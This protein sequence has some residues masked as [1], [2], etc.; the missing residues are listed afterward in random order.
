MY[1]ISNTFFLRRE[2]LVSLPFKRVRCHK[3]QEES[4]LKEKRVSNRYVMAGIQLITC[5]LC[6][7][8]TGCDDLRKGKVESLQTMPVEL[9][10]SLFCTFQ[11]GIF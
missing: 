2:S 9:G 3:N 10:M 5:D 1:A 7:D 4:I 8:W 11:E 6:F